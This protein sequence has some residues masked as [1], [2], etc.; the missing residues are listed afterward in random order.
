MDWE[1]ILSCSR[2]D[3]LLFDERDRRIAD[4]AS[5]WGGRSVWEPSLSQSSSSE[6]PSRAETPMT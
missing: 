6:P 2:K 3:N 4:Q 5:V 1:E